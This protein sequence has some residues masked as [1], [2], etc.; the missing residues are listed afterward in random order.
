MATRENA[1]FVHFATAGHVCGTC[2]RVDFHFFTFLRIW[3]SPILL[4]SLF[5]FTHVIERN[6]SSNFTFIS[7]VYLPILPKFTYETR[8]LLVQYM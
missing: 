6:E 8:S 4:S 2:A 1:L 5:C 3:S 7:H